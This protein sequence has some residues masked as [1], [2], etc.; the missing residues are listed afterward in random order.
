MFDRI[1]PRYDLTNTSLCVGCDSLWRRR[2][3]T[4]VASWQPRDILDFA[5]GSGVLAEAIQ[6]HNPVA[7]YHGR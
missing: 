1:A 3:A 7:D 2:V 5:T 6:R 4:L